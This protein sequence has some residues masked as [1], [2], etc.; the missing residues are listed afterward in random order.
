MLYSTSALIMLAAGLG[1][2]ILELL[3]AALGQFIG[4]S[5]AA[6]TVLLG[7]VLMQSLSPY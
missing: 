1:I 4:A 5:V 3:N 7:L 6:V 2:H